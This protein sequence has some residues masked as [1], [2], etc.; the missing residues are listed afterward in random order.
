MFHHTRQTIIRDFSLCNL[1]DFKYFR[2]PPKTIPL[3]KYS[4]GIAAISPTVTDSKILVLDFPMIGTK[5]MMI[6][7]IVKIIFS[8]NFIS[9]DI[10]L[11]Y[12]FCLRIRKLSKRIEANKNILKSTLST[13]KFMCRFKGMN[14]RFSNSSSIKSKNRIRIIPSYFDR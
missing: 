5:N 7:S 11:N 3:Y 1:V 2:K 9:G 12:T 13:R 14:V 4:S 6:N 10:G 8:F